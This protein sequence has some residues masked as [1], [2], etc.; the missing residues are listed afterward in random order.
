MLVYDGGDPSA[1]VKAL[2]KQR[3]GIKLV[4]NTA[5][6]KIKLEKGS[7]LW[8]LHKDAMQLDCVDIEDMYLGRHKLD[9]EETAAKWDEIMTT[10]RKLFASS[11][12]MDSEET[13]PLGDGGKLQTELDTAI[14]A[15]QRASFM[16]RSLQ[17]N[18]ILSKTDKN[19]SLGKDDKSP[20]TIADFAVQALIIDALSKAFP[21][22]RF[23]AEEDSRLL[24]DDSEITS[25]IVEALNQASDVVDSNGKAWD[26]ERLYKTIDKGGWEGSAKSGR[27]W[28]LDPVDGTK[29][30]MRGEHYCIALA[31]L[32]NGIPQLSTLGCPNVQLLKVLDGTDGANKANMIARGVDLG[33]NDD[34]NEYTPHVYPSNAGCVFFAVTG[35]GAYVRSL[36]MAPGAALE[37]NVQLPLKS[38]NKTVLCESVEASHGNR[39]VT[40]SVFTALGMTQD[41]VRLDGQCKYAMVGAGAFLLYFTP[42]PGLI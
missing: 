36:A 23:I 2:A 21:E 13:P 22:D 33:G 3:S 11:H 5:H 29:G 34:N 38:N 28:V 32:V 18:L 24:Q 20:V 17:H 25:L 10:R 39:R 40:Q 37:V 27:I 1:A 16:S 30:F 41:Y 14:R 7:M 26:A 42:Y 8:S 31:L 12:K 19:V 15:V 35:S 9:D 4:D 6:A